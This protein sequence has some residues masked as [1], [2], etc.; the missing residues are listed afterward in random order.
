MKTIQLTQGYVAIV[1]DE[2]YERVVELK[3]YYANGYA[4]SNIPTPSGGQ[5]TIQLQRLIL[6]APD[7]LKVDH[8][9]TDGLDNRREN[10]RT[11]TQSQNLCNRGKNRNNTSGHKGVTFHKE[12]GKWMAQIILNGKRNYLGLFKDK[13]EAA[14]A[15][16]SK[17]AELHG[18]FART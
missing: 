8:K 13:Q 12:R 16:S 2:D 9:S 15:Y 6:S 7:G 4:Q 5:K 14:D 11:A 10:L 18:E 1:D 3:W 17:A